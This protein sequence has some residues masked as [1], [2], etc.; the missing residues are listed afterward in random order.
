MAQFRIAVKQGSSVQR[1]GTIRPVSLTRI[2]KNTEITRRV[3]ALL[4][5]AE[6]KGLTQAE[7]ARRI[8][9]NRSII[10]EWKAGRAEPDIATFARLCAELRI[11]VD[12]A[13]GL[14]DAAVATLAAL[15][16]KELIALESSLRQAH[17]LVSNAAL[18]ARGRAVAATQA[19]LLRNGSTGQGAGK[20]RKRPR[21]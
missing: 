15:S 9:R 17:E 18:A 13:L 14:D 3:K 6:R 12:Q 5:L 11:T 8:D 10:S 1:D 2:G 20:E 16:D 19:A 7:L 21:R 4:A